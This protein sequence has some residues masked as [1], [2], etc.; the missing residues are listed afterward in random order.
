MEKT[1][2]SIDWDYFIQ[3]PK[4]YW[5][6]YQENKKNLLSLWY[7][8]YIQL[9]SRGI[10]IY[11]LFR[12]SSEVGVFWER[13]KKHFRFAKGLWAYVSDSHALSYDLAKEH[14]CKVVYLFDAHAD[15]GYGG[16]ASLDF[17]VNCANWLGK[18]L[19]EQQVQE[20][21]IVYSPATWE[22]PEDFAE[23]NRL[24]SI[25]YPSSLAE[26][27]KEIPVSVVH[28]CRSG[29]WTPPW[30]DQKFW[31]FVQ[32]AGIPYKIINCQRRRWDVDHLNLAQQIDYLLA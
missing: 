21:H 5:L 18:L 26:L 30:L 4:E 7:K 28:I 32:E 17:E 24:Y 12:L 14:D 20:A 2:L 3:A 16:L 22:K 23:L 11:K 19:K 9:K 13:I 29:A 27:D 8:R 10:S 31:E 25:H 15:L 1:L 6:S